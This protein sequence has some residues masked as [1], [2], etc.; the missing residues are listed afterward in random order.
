MAAL[1][2]RD[3]QLAGVRRQ[4][5]D[6]SHNQASNKETLIDM[7]AALKGMPLLSKPAV[8]SRMH[9]SHK[10]ASGFAVRTHTAA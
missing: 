10:I 8:V 5:Q 7:I 4:L 6:V 2:E 9:G 3:E 1:N